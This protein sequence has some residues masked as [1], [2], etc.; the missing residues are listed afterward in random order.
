MK[1]VITSCLVATLTAVAP[2]QAEE[3]SDIDALR[4]LDQAYAA[5][6]IEGDADGVMALFTSDATLVPHHGDKPVK[7]HEAI[8]NF[9]F[10]PDYPPTIVPEWTR[11]PAEFFASATELF[12]TRPVD[13]ADHEPAL[14]A[15]L[16]RFYRQDPAR[17]AA[18]RCRQGI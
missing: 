10:N 7:G 11:T 13:L 8:R 15:E 14:Y 4:E 18:D 16:R 17:R 1:H 9:W 3:Q 6:W 2:L 12:F 5:E